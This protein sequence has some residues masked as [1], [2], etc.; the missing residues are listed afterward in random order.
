MLPGAVAM[1]IVIMFAGRLALARQVADSAAYDAARSA[2]LARTESV[3]ITQARNAA[4]ASFTAQGFRCQPLTVQPNTAGFRVPV[5]QPATVSVRVICRVDLRDIVE[6][7]GMPVS[8]F[9]TL[10]ST[11]VSPLDTYRSRT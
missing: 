1:V 6:L 10:E 11:F 8:D 4:S 7:P 2:S 3:A 9:I 5:G